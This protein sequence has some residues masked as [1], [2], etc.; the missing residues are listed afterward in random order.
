MLGCPGTLN[1][2][3]QALGP[4]SEDALGHG[5]V[6]MEHIPEGFPIQDQS[7]HLAQGRRGGDARGGIKHG[8]FADA[9][10]LRGISQDV[11]LTLLGPVPSLCPWSDQGRL[12]DFCRTRFGGPLGPLRGACLAAGLGPSFFLGRGRALTFSSR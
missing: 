3:S 8:H 1:Q 2:G 6:V 7:R 10:T 4:H 11:A 12:V 9:D 5:R